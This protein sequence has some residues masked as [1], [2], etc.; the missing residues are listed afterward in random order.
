MMAA[1]VTLFCSAKVSRLMAM[2]RRSTHEA[3]DAGAD[4]A[5]RCWWGSN[6]C[7]SK[8]TWVR[9]TLTL[10]LVGAGLRVIKLETQTI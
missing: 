2:A 6:G 3:R 4:E 7:T 5:E 9:W 8:V 1:E 10:A